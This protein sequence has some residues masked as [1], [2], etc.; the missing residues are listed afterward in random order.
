MSFQVSARARISVIVLNW[1]GL[2]FLGPC[3]ES[4]SKQTCPKFQIVL[5]DN[6]SVDGSV[7]YVRT[8]FPSVRIIENLKNLGFAEGNN[9]GFRSSAADYVVLLNNDTRASPDFV[10]TLQLEVLAARFSGKTAQSDTAQCSQIV[11]SLSLGSCE[12]RSCSCL[13]DRR[14]TAWRIL[15]RRCC[16]GKVP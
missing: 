15:V 3:L 8:N 7:Q 2:R 11:A 13:G 4:L 12:P 5:V 14:G 1:N 6:G 10:E 16:T 9:V